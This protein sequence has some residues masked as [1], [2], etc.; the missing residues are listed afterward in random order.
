MKGFL[1]MFIHIYTVFY[2]LRGFVGKIRVY[3]RVRPIS[4]SELE[5][6]CV[7]SVV[8]VRSHDV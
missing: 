4:K 5:R 8:K 2:N 6:G 1:F 3:V 7:E